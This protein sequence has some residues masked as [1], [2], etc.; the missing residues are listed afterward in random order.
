MI[1]SD[2]AMDINDEKRVRQRYVMTVLYFATNGEFWT[3]KSNWLDSERSE[4]DW[5]GV[6]CISGKNVIMNIILPENNVTGTLPDEIT[7]LPTLFGWNMSHNNISGNLPENMFERLEALDT[8]DLEDNQISGTIPPITTPH[9]RSGLRKVDLGSNQLTGMFP[10]FPNAEFVL[11]ERNNLTSIDGRYS[12]SPPSLKKFRGF[13]NEIS[14]PL[15]TT[16]NLPNL[17]EL[18]LGYN[19]LTGTIPHDL[20]NLPSL[21]TLWLD[22]C[23]LTGPLPGYSESNSMHRLWL[24]SNSLSG[25]IPLNF[26]W[27]WTKLYSIKLQDNLLTGSIDIDQCDRWKILGS[28]E[29]SATETLFS[30]KENERGSTW[31]FDVDCKIECACCTTNCASSTSSNFGGQR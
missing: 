14:G 5:Y 29:A 23:N 15:P 13:H 19:F 1:N 18:D 10:F 24:D 27:N 21:K 22:H 2:A 12:T 7:A 26:G 16:W 28:D 4:C 17:I 25:S 30:K 11:F 31:T 20:W 3:K 6:A 9:S 8:L